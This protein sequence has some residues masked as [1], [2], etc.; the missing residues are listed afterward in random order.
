MSG[1]AFVDTNVLIYAHDVDAGS[2]HEVAKELLRELWSERAGALSLQVLQEFYTNV[3]REI[4]SP[5]SKAGA[6]VVVNNYANWCVETTL[7]EI[8]TAFR[9]EDEAHIG[10]WDSLIIAS[11]LKSGATRLLSE[12]LNSGQAVAGIKIENPFSAV[13]KPQHR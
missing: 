12:D 9:I 7:N 2:K 11:A 10:F 4:A 3:T 8:L 1:K 6:R 13:P 5:L